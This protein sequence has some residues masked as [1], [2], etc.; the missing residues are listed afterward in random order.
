MQR[1]ALLFHRLVQ[2]HLLGMPSPVLAAMAES[3]E[4]ARWW[5]S[6]TSGAP[7][8]AGWQLHAEKALVCRIGAH[9]LICKFDLLA[10]R[11][12]KAVIY[13]WK[14]FARRP[15]NE[16]LAARMQTR[17]YRAMLV[18]AGAEL[19]GGRPFVALG[20]FDGLLVRGVPQ[21][22]ATAGL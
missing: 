17:T 9:R 22:P 20:Y 18:R 11:D 8:L 12:G 1:D 15:T 2:Q 5:S 6:F 3:H 10:V 14:T 16:W 7:D 4:I 19:N 13:D 21:N